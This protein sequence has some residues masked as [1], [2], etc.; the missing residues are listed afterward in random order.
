MKY[1]KIYKFVKE[2]EGMARVSSVLLKNYELLF[3]QY[4][5]GQGSSNYPTVGMLDFSKLCK[6]WGIV[7]KKD[8]S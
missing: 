3:E 2:P 4:V 1:S 7:N 8:L 5:F 6:A